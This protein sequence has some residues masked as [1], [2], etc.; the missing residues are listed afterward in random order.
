MSITNEISRISDEVTA[1]SDLM[2]EIESIL[3][4]KAIPKPNLQEK[5]VTPANVSQIITA[6]SG[7]DGLRKVTV[8]AAAGT[9]FKIKYMLCLP[10]ETDDAQ[11]QPAEYRFNVYKNGTLIDDFIAFNGI[12]E[13]AFDLEFDILN[14]IIVLEPV[15]HITSAGYYIS[16]ETMVVQGYNN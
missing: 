6:D 7:Y 16:G 8:G 12:G 10:L 9:Y 13:M 1:Q 4:N 2:D 15:E 5:T 11:G 14:D 3:A